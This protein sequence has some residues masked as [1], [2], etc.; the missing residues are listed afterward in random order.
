MDDTLLVLAQHTQNI[1][2]LISTQWSLLMSSPAGQDLAPSV[3]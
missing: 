3:K 1:F 2:T